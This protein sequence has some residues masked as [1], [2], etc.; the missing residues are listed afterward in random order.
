MPNRFLPI[1]EGTSQSQLLSML[2]KNFA[3]LDSDN[4]TKVFQG[5]NKQPAV[6]VGKLPD[7]RYGIYFSDGTVTTIITA[8]GFEQND[9]TNDRV[10]LG[11]E[12]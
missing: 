10:F 3:E 12:E 9:G 11:N 6:V 2:N 7:G 1:T 5:D 4:V 8:S